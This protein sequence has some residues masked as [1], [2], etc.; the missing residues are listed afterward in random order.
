VD[1]VSFSIPH[2][3]VVL[4]LVG[5]SG[6]GKSTLARIV[7]G[8]LKPTSGHVKYRGTDIWT[9]DRRWQ[10]SF[11]RDVQ[12]VFQDPYGAY[13]PVYK[14]GRA[15]TVP[16]RKFGLAA[17]A[18]QAQARIDESLRAVGLR[19]EEV[20][21]RYPHQLS[22]G[23]RQRVML[24]RL[25]LMRPRLIVADEPV[26]MIDAGMRATFLNILLDFARLHDMST[27]FITHDLSTAQYLGG[28]IIV[29]YRGRVVET[30][31]TSE[32]MDTP[33][34]P[35]SK[36][37]IRS[38]PVPDPRKRWQD[39]LSA[40]PDQETVQSLSRDCCLYATRCP[41]AEKVCWETRPQLRMQQDGEGS[42]S[43]HKVAC[44]MYDPAH[45]T[46]PFA[47]GDR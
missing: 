9:K 47:L 25:H 31:E 38:I 46:I 22:G 41:N 24:A 45:W 30:G 39:H 5:E 42:G 13:N 8:L 33:L 11:R 35:Y 36:L 26:S 17:G 2:E 43:S 34:H 15:L 4:N 18:Q 27:L 14:V 37:L 19:P 16:V 28:D 20:L 6:S 1:G 21:D 7:L 40:V 10:R 3:P 44:H 23:Q 29:L 12:A 32:V